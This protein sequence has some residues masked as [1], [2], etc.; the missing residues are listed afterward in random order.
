MREAV[1]VGKRLDLAVAE[2]EYAVKSR[3][4]GWTSTIFTGVMGEKNPFV[5]GL[6]HGG[7]VFEA[8]DIVM[9]EVQANYEGYFGQVVRTFVVGTA[10]ADQKH[11]V[12]TLVQAYREATAILK[13]G[14]IVSELFGVL[15]D[16]A[17]RGNCEIGSRCGHGMGYGMAESWSVQA[18]DH[19]VLTAGSY[20]A[21]HP[22]FKYRDGIVGYGGCFAM[23]ETG[24]ELLNSREDP[25]EI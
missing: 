8:G 9:V 15:S 18:D 21:L 16:V 10:S 2:A 4:A 5:W 6:N 11:V 3:G 1:E 22:I 13:P 23:T 24:A 14:V 25:L 19:S 7:Q 12:E 20:G 17:R